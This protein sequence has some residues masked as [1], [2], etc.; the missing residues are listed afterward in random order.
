[1]ISPDC[2]ASI[3]AVDRAT[4]LAPTASPMPP[5]IAVV[6]R[7]NTHAARAVLH[8]PPE[9]IRPR[10][11]AATSPLEAVSLMTAGKLKTGLPRMAGRAVLEGR[12]GGGD[13]PTIPHLSPARGAG[14]SVLA[15]LT[16][17]FR[18]L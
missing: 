17:R 3:S 10:A 8:S 6:I 14:L 13:P 4:P 12:W 7:R 18:R 16:A 11:I 1:M 5:L 2:K 9:N 15:R